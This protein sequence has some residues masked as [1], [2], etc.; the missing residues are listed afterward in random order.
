MPSALIVSAGEKGQAVLRDMLSASRFDR[1]TTVSNG[2]D[3][4]RALIS[5]GYELVVINTPLTDEFGHELAAHAAAGGA[6]CF[7]GGRIVCEAPAGESGILFVE[8]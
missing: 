1:V 3:A 7:S 2:S 6:A 4:R 5:Q 8:L